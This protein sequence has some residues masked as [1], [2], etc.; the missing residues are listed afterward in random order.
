MSCDPLTL[1][2]DQTV[3]EVVTIF[4]ENKI[5]G[6]PVLNDDAKLIGLFTKSHI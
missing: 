3:G 1:R 4:M 5:D 6:A 2:P